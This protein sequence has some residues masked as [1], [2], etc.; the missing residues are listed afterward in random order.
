MS[1]RSA[2]N[3]LYTGERMIWATTDNETPN[4]D[5]ANHRRAPDR[6][7]S[8]TTP[9][10]VR[11]SPLQQGSPTPTERPETTA[12][13]VTDCERDTLLRKHRSNVPYL[14][15]EPLAGE[16]LGSMS[17][18]GERVGRIDCVRRHGPE[19]RGKGHSCRPEAS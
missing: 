14:R 7:I 16:N 2:P 11:L 9:R 18:V 8:D 5:Q 1:Y 12:T 10:N 6:P 19:R 17:G 4:Q 15:T 13:S 3:L